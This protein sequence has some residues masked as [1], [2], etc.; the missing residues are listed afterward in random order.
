MPTRCPDTFATFATYIHFISED[1]FGGK[2]SAKFTDPAGLDFDVRN[3]NR[4]V[5]VY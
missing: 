2:A 1:L 4:G 5:P 3:S